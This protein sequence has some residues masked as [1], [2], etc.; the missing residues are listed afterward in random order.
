MDKIEVETQ[1]NTSASETK[2]DISDNTKEHGEEIEKTPSETNDYA[3]DET[4]KHRKSICRIFVSQYMD[5]T[6]YGSDD[7][8]V[9]LSHKDKSVL[10]WSVNIE[11]NGPQQPDVYF[12]IDKVN[13]GKDLQGHSVQIDRIK[14]LQLYNSVLSKK[15]LLL[16]TS[17]AFWLIDLNSDRTNSERFIELKRP[18]SSC[19]DEARRLGRD[20]IGFLPNGDLIQVSLSDRKIYKYCFKD[21]NIVPWK[22]SQINDI[23]IPE[24]LYGQ[25]KLHCPIYRTK[26]FLLVETRKKLI[27]Q[28]DLLTMNLERQFTSD[29]DFYWDISVIMNKNQTLLAIAGHI[30]SMENGISIYKG[31]I[32]D[33][34]VE[35]ITLKNNSERL[36]YHGIYRNKLVDPYQVYDE[37]EILMT[38]I[39]YRNSIYSLSTFKIIQSM[40]NEI[41]DQVEIKKVLSS[42]FDSIVLTDEVEIKNHGLC[43]IDLYNDYGSD[44]VRFKKEDKSQQI[45]PCP[46]ILSFKLLNNQDLVI[47]NMEGISI[48]TMSELIITEGI[49]WFRRRYFWRNNEWNNVYEK[50]EEYCHYH[51]DIKFTSSVPKFFS[52]SSK[53]DWWDRNDIVNVVIKDKLVSSKYGIEMLKIAIKERCYE[54]VQQI[55]ESIQ[56]Y[57]E[58]YMTIIS[59]NLAELCDYYP[60]YVIKYISRTSIMLSPHCNHIGNSKNTSLHSH[61]NYIKESTMDNI[62]FKFISTLYKGLIQYLMI[63][64]DIQT[65]SFIVPFPQICVY[66]DNSKNNDHENENND[67]ES[68]DSKNNDHENRRTEKDQKNQKNHDTCTGFLVIKLKIITIL[69]KMITGLKIIMMMPKNNSVWNEFLYK[70]KSILFCNIDS[71]NFYNWWNF[72]AIIDFKWKTFGRVYYYLIWLFYTIF[73]VCY[74][75]ASTLEQKSIPDFYFKLLF[76][77]SIIFGSIF[78]IFEIR[79]CLWNYK[80]YFND[81]WNLF[82]VGA[83][84]LPIIT[85]IFWLINK[86]PPLWLTA[87]SIILLSFKFLLFFRVFKSYGIYFAIILGVAKTVY[88]FLVVLFFIVLGYAQAFFIVLRS[89]S[90]N[91]DNDPRNLATKYDFVNPDGTISNTTTIIQDPDSNTNLFNWFPTSLL[92]VYNLLTGDSGSLSLFTYRERS[93]MTILLVTFTFFTVIYLMNLFIGLLNLAI[94]DFNKKEEFLLQK[95]QIIMEIELFYL[96][97]WQRNNKKWFP[98]WIY[99][100]IPITEI[101]KLLNAIDNEQTVFNYPPFVSEKLR[102]LVVLTNDNKKQTKEELTQELK[103]QNNKLE[104]KIDRIIKYI[105]IEQDSEEDKKKKQDNKLEKQIKQTKEELTR[106]LKEKMDKVEQKMES[107]MESL[108]KIK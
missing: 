83:Y 30:L 87:I 107:I 49:F 89:N 22:Y 63:K 46:N 19:H 93:I 102:K 9:T 91:D 74:A 27:L 43:K 39:V 68:H 86:S 70:Q 13:E 65:V 44:Y 106:E 32:L 71:S 18:V 26:L 11:K 23:E 50:F 20:S 99:Y 42:N 7:Y 59:L 73:Y 55:I 104:K 96:L 82:D 2:I 64:E 60:D 85:S 35:F 88:P 12:K 34:L 36:L 3:F 75:L 78:L 6:E 98:D 52:L 53:K 62:I 37:I 15:I 57:S 66:P 47:I 28:F 29:I 17:Y 40:L 94:D 103:E 48:Y 90:I 10:G 31:D 108:S 45:V 33:K 77:I 14:Y 79:H 101:R 38:Q 92:A 72:A 41:I 8:V 97:P 16:C 51:Y 54:V 61:T 76:I 81:I 1:N 4:E 69:K 105:G 67:H 80:Y 56:D 5:D 100:D 25:V 84:L 24:S 58:N 95:A 21:K